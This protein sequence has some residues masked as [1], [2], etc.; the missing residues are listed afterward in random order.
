MSAV[1]Q[2]V[3]EKAKKSHASEH[4]KNHPQLFLKE[5]K[6]TLIQVTISTITH[7]RREML[8]EERREHKTSLSIY[9]L[10]TGMEQCILFSKA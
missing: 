1:D 2:T 10:C 3:V 9:I 5:V 4:P 6:K 7:M 8:I